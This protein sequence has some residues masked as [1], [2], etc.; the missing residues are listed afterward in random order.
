MTNTN[1]ARTILVIDDEPH[2]VTYLEML[3]QDT[4]Y[5]TVSAVNGKVGM[6]MARQEMPDL[7]CLDITMPEE[8][9]IRFYRKLKDDPA[10]A[11]IPVVVV[12][13]VTGLGGQPEPFKRFFSTRKSVPAP[14]GF[15]SKP[16]D[17]GEFLGMIDEVLS[18]TK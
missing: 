15:L 13:A 4:G 16:I 6:E 14:E 17:Q 11:H 8:S 18:S 3:L 9:G 12:T 7:I 2:V 5:K 10:L 1:D